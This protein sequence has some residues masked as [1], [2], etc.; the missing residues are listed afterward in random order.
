M[1]DMD[2]KENQEET[3]EEMLDRINKS[4]KSDASSHKV[5][6]VR[7]TIGKDDYRAFLYH[8]V[9]G[10]KKWILPTYI[11]LPVVISAAF[12][13]ADGAFNLVKFLIMSLVLYVLMFGIII[14]RTERSLKKIGKASPETLRLTDTSFT[15]LSDSISHT[16]NGET[17]NIPYKNLLLLSPAKTRTVLYFTGRKAMIMRNEDIEKVMPL[18]DFNEFIKSKI[19]K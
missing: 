3:L 10:K 4:D 16:K 15:F 17:I 12:S 11:L 14:F 13:I 2:N 5:F 1:T 6:T 7:S 19:I 18:N 9:F 8:S